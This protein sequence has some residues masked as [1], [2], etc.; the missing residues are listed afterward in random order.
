MLHDA[1]SWHDE[2]NDVVT[3]IRSRLLAVAGTSEEAGFECVLMQGSGTFGVESVLGSVIPASGRA[4]ILTNGAYGDRI[5]AMA[6][7][8]K[9]DHRVLRTAEDVVPSAHEVE[10]VLREDAGVTH[11]VVVHCETTTGILNPL[12]S[13]GAAVKRNGRR[14]IVDAMSSFGAI[15]IDLD[16]VGVDFLISSANKCI[17]GVPGFSFVLARREPL[18]ASEGCARSLSLDLFSQWRGFQKNRQFRYTPPTH[19]LLAF[20]Q[21]LNELEQEGGVQARGERYRQNHGVLMHGMSE[22]GLRCFL[23]AEVQSYIITAFHCPQDPAFEFRAFYN[24]LSQ[25]GMIIYPGKL[26]QVD[27]F[28]IGNI[29]RLFPSDIEHLLAALKAGLEAL[30]CRLPFSA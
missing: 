16:A 2:F 30:G 9:I 19:A 3:S 6:K 25:R 15:P 7:V 24:Q 1:G 18:L 4:L 13:I 20:D 22:L 21:A 14:L 10:A 29:G 5:V 12:E 23:S 17:E 27:T 28:R 8:L 11:V 26:T